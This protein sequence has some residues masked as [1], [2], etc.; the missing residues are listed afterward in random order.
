MSF[1]PVGGKT[2]GIQI[3][4]S[5]KARLL[6]TLFGAILGLMRLNFLSFEADAVRHGGTLK[7]QRQLMPGKFIVMDEGD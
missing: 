1:V 2:L 3:T 4:I 6:R 7:Q 5:R